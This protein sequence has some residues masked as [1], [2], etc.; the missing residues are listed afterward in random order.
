MPVED[1]AGEEAL[2]AAPPAG[3]GAGAQG[4]PA[5]VLTVRLA[6]PLA[7]GTYRVRLQGVRN[8]RGLVGGG[9]ALFSYPAAVEGGG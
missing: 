5:R 9:E 3:A 2:D 8:L 7:S 4:L 1:A 6:E